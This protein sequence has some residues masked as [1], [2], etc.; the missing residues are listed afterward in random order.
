MQNFLPTEKKIIENIII[1]I[2]NLWFT[3]YDLSMDLPKD[4]RMIPWKYESLVFQK[5]L[6]EQNGTFLQDNIK[7]FKY[8]SCFPCPTAGGTV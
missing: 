5:L 2:E 4:S 3:R 1:K 7:R 8:L 6:C